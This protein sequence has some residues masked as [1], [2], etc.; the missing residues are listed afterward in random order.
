MTITEPDL[1]LGG[2]VAK[3]PDIHPATI[4]EI[5]TIMDAVEAEQAE[6]EIRPTEKQVL[7]AI[8]HECL[9]ANVPCTQRQARQIVGFFR[10]LNGRR[11]KNHWEGIHDHLSDKEIDNF[12]AQ[13]DVVVPDDTV[14]HRGSNSA[15]DLME[16]LILHKSSEALGIYH[17]TDEVEHV[18]YCDAGVGIVER[19]Y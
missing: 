15:H 11:R 8:V 1:R 17:T 14:A 10:H 3:H 7:D 12:H 13:L 16:R 4:D 19:D 18:R 9:L 5:D 2:S 6:A